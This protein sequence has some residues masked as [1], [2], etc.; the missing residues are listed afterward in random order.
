MVAVG[1]NSPY[2]P[3]SMLILQHK[4]SLTKARRRW[5]LYQARWTPSKPLNN[6]RKPCRAGVSDAG[7]QA[8]AA[9]SG[10]THLNLDSRHV[11][12]DGLAHLTSLVKLRA[13]DLFGARIS[14]AGCAHLR[15]AF[16]ALV[17]YTS[18]K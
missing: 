1:D 5:R 8:V 15:C 10:L 12:D 2:R 9:L 14:D 18:L 7:L 4:V 16:S 11:T 6:N 13:L 3:V 17:L